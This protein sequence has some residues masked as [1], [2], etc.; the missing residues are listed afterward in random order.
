MGHDPEIAKFDRIECRDN[1]DF[2]SKA[3]LPIPGG[4]VGISI[5]YPA[6][7]RG[8]RVELVWREP[9]RRVP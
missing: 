4:E 1:G 5:G 9:A 7:T 8:S 6:N 2:P 3:K